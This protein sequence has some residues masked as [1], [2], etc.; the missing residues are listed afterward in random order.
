MILSE[1]TTSI[2]KNRNVASLAQFSRAV[3]C[4]GM[5]RLANRPNATCVACESI[6]PLCGIVLPSKLVSGPRRDAT[7]HI[8]TLRGME[9]QRVNVLLF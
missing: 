5:L 6:R 7:G 8:W 9:S 2:P 1:F 3:E 4:V